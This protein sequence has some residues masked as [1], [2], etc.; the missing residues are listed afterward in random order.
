ML[1]QKNAD[2]KQQ[3]QNKLPVLPD[4]T[5]ECD[6]TADIG[7]LECG[8]MSYCMEISTA[9]QTRLGVCVKVGK[10]TSSFEQSHRQLEQ[11]YY[12]GSFA[13]YACT[14]GNPYDYYDCDCSD[15]DLDSASGT[16][17]CKGRTFSSSSMN[18]L[19]HMSNH[20]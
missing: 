7:I 15:F 16:I 20:L 2:G 1:L 14:E 4:Q 10:K 18:L 13:Q 6:P 12:H 3:F 11:D 8:T 9:K 17:S 19:S 5:M